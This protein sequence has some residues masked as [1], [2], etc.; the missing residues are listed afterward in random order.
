MGASA[1][2]PVG[3]KSSHPS[4]VA[5]VVGLRC[6]MLP[7]AGCDRLGI[8][9]SSNLAEVKAEIGHRVSALA[10]SAD[11]GHQQQLAG[12][13]REV[14]TLQQA[15]L[16]RETI[17]MAKG[18]LMARS[19]CSPDEAFD[20]LRRASQRIRKLASIAS[21]IVV[22]NSGSCSARHLGQAAPAGGAEFRS[23]HPD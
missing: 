7:V 22:S 3:L 13:Q 6:R 17:G 19:C 11:W 8:W 5:H 10:S 18:I 9:R 16:S 20:M 2:V 23:D 14:E 15:L 12:L 4:V 21:E 1:K